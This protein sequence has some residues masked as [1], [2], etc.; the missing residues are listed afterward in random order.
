MS[1]KMEIFKTDDNGNQYLYERYNIDIKTKEKFGQYE[2]FHD[3][4]SHKR[5]ILAY[6]NGNGN[7]HGEFLQWYP[8][9]DLELHSKYRDGKKFGYSRRLSPD[10]EILREDYYAFDGSG[11]LHGEAK[12]FRDGNLLCL[13]VYDN[14]VRQRQEN[15]DNGKKTEEYF[16]KDGHR[17]KWIAFATC[18]N[19]KGD[20][21]T[22]YYPFDE[23]DKDEII[24][25]YKKEKWEE[26]NGKR[27]GKNKFYSRDGSLIKT[28]IYGVMIHKKELLNDKVEISK[29]KSLTNYKE[30]L[31]NALYDSKNFIRLPPLSS[32][33]TS[34]RR[35]INK[36]TVKSITV[37]D[38]GNKSK[39]TIWLPS[40][41]W[42]VTL[43]SD[44]QCA[45]VKK[46]IEQ[47]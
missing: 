33:D 8:G 41:P 37:F 40:E 10:G 18:A 9:G 24:Q 38:G 2:Q 21:H 20:L 1:D 28:I 26:C 32:K 17:I 12:I 15:W 35:F 19:H 36:K 7:L 44:E 23:K 27:I 22:T 6:Y 29:G 39:V 4:T 14:G 30:I 5:K 34:N 43:D 45:L 31:S 11:K 42:T 46:F 47:I 16:F 3:R 13:D 25:L